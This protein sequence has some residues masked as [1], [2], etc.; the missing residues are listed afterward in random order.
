MPIKTTAAELLHRINDRSPQGHRQVPFVSLDQTSAA[1]GVLAGAVPSGFV[2]LAT[3]LVGQ[4]NDPALGT[5]VG[6]P[7]FASA[8]FL[9]ANSSDV[10]QW[11]LPVMAFRRRQ[12]LF[13]FQDSPNWRNA[14]PGNAW[15]WKPKYAIPIPEGWKVSS[16]VT[17]GAL[18]NSAAAYG[19]LVPI[20]TAQLLGYA[21]QPGTTG[22]STRSFSIAFS[23]GDATK[24]LITGRSDKCVRILDVWIRLQPVVAGTTCTLTLAQ[25]DGET[26]WRG[27]NNNPSDLF[28]RRFSP[29]WYLKKG[30]GVDLVGTAN[31][32]SVIVTYE[33]V[34]PEDVPHSSWWASVVPQLPTPSLT[35]IGVFDAQRAISTAITVYYPC[36]NSNGDTKTATLPGANNQFYVRGYDFTVQKDSSAGTPDQLFFAVSSGTAGGL[37]ELG[38]AVVGPQTNFQVTPV[39]SG[40]D[41]DQMVGLSVDDINIPCPRS[42]AGALWV[43]SLAVHSG[44]I[45]TP[46]T[47]DV[48][49]DEWYV[50]LWGRTQPAQL[51]D[52]ANRGT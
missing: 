26:F 8:G 6:S 4:S 36:I 51:Q 9:I 42:T 2:F 25:D 1:G 22:D 44:A 27:A 19:H 41:H 12:Q 31:T 39:F 17:I 37:I 5:Q 28:E 7:D 3:H 33:Y 10:T 29:E 50:N 21:N 34:N 18:G 16:A 48:D 52:E 35:S 20:A 47:T 45:S 15:A 49:T 24:Q 13:E 38:V 14:R 46:T 23:N 30:Q 40:S 11:L 32:H 43:D